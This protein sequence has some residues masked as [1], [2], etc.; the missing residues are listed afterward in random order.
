M[1]LRYGLISVDDHV[2]E[3]PDL[4]GR[5]LSHRWGDR[6]P[7]LRRA[8]DGTEQWVV[9]GQLLL[10]GRASRAGA[11]MPDRNREPS[12]WEEVPAAAYLPSERRKA[13]DAAGIDYSVRYP[14]VAGLAGG[15]CGR[16]EDPA[17]GVACVQ[18]S[19]DWVLAAGA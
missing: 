4:W 5:R 12:R 19:Q 17:V 15:T 2:Q 14:T 11:L 9:D 8:A 10:D 6:M 18:A 3:P 1:Q 16:L 7:Q 13:M